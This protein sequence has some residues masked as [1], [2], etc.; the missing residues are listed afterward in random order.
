MTALWI[1]T[2]CKQW[3]SCTLM[4]WQ[5]KTRLVSPSDKPRNFA[6]SDSRKYLLQ[7]LDTQPCRNS[8]PRSRKAQVSEFYLGLWAENVESL[9]WS[10]RMLSYAAAMLSTLFPALVP[11]RNGLRLYSK[12]IVE[13]G[14]WNKN[15]P[16]VNS[17]TR[18]RSYLFLFC[19]L[20]RAVWQVPRCAAARRVSGP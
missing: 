18:G 12:P 7:K 13:E 10:V 4:R 3:S 9:A 2:D 1:L 17:T 15:Y 16:H 19:I 11:P 14:L 5:L 8:S 6:F 20:L